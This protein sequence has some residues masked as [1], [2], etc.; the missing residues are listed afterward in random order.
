MGESWS[1]EAR[2]AAQKSTGEKGKIRREK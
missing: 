2:E 1:C